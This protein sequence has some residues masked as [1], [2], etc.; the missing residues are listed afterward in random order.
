MLGMTNPRDAIAISRT[1]ETAEE[2][3]R[4][5][6]PAT[7]SL[8]RLSDH[9]DPVKAEWLFRGQSNGESGDRWSLRPAAHRNADA[10]LPF[11]QFQVK[12]I[13]ETGVALR[14]MEIRHVINFS[15]TVDLH[16]LI[17]PSDSH[18]L[19]DSRLIRKPRWYSK[20]PWDDPTHFPPAHLV[21]M[22]GLAQ[23]H[24][25]PTRLLDW[26]S[27]PLVAAYFA[28]LPVAKRRAPGT[29]PPE[30][31]CPYFSIFAVHR[32]VS[33]VCAGLD[34]E[35]HFLSVPTAT[36]ANLHAQ[37]GQFSL[38]QPLS[39]PGNA[40]LPAIDDVLRE[41]ADKIWHIED[42]GWQYL[43]PLLIEFRIPVREAR[44]AL[45]TLAT[46]GVSAASVFPGLQGIVDALR[47]RRYYQW[48]SPS[49]R[50]EH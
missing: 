34:P 3:F 36:N 31:E 5:L 1:L 11:E 39:D 19:R 44:T 45:L 17:V 21:A 42:G 33:R 9:L 48:A 23:H 7:G 24:G 49:D 13:Q 12:A 10:F 41:H 18:E 35:I 8:W 50:A 43:F 25:L 32:G 26:T 15:A 40:A 2:L 30:T 6:S 47:E 46:M 20:S 16:G 22:F 14:E 37:G 28:A 29:K 38:V 4:E 27:K